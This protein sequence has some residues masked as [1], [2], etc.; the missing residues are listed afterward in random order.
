V[1][2]QT[3]KQLVSV[4][5]DTDRGEEVKYKQVDGQVL[6]SMKTREK[7][8]LLW[9]V[10]MQIKEEAN[11][12][13]V[14]VFTDQK[15][16]YFGLWGRMSRIRG[17]LRKELILMSLAILTNVSVYAQGEK[18]VLESLPNPI[19]LYCY[20][21]GASIRF[22]GQVDGVNKVLGGYI[23]SSTGN[24]SGTLTSYYVGEQPICQ[25]C[26]VADLE[27]CEPDGN[28]GLVCTRP[29][30][31][32]GDPY[33]CGSPSENVCGIRSINLSG[34]SFSSELDC[35]E[36]DPNLYCGSTMSSLFS[37]YKVS[38]PIASKQ[39][40]FIKLTSRLERTNNN[41]W[42]LTNNPSL[43]GSWKQVP[44]KSSDEIN[45]TEA[46]L[47]GI[48]LS[49]SG[50][51]YARVKNNN[52]SSCR[53][54]DPSLSFQL[55]APAPDFSLSSTQPTCNGGDNGTITI[56][57]PTGNLTGYRVTLLYNVLDNPR[58]QYTEIV[59]STS[60]PI[61]IDKAKL[62]ADNI[63]DQS[64]IVSGTWYVKVQNNDADSNKGN[65]GITKDI[66]VP[67]TPQLSPTV[68]SSTPVKCFG[69]SNGTLT[70]TINGG[71]PGFTYKFDNS[72]TATD[73]TDGT[74]RSPKFTGLSGGAHSVIVTDNNTCSSTALPFTINS[75]T[76]LLAASIQ[77]DKKIS[78]FER[79]DGELSVNTSGGQ[80]GYTY[81]WSNSTTTQSISALPAAEYTVTVTDDYGCVKTDT[82]TLTRPQKL[83]FDLSIA[84]PLSCANTADGVL[85]VT[86]V[87][88][89]QG[90]VTYSWSTDQTES[91]ISN[92]SHSVPYSVI[93]RDEKGCSATK[94]TTLTQPPAHTVSL[95]IAYP[96]EFNGSAIRCYG[97]SNG[98]ITA[99][100]RDGN[101]TIVQASR[102][103]WFKNAE[104]SS[105]EGGPTKTFIDGLGEG[106]Y[107]VKVPYNNGRCIAES[108]FIPL[109]EPDPITVEVRNENAALF[110]DQTLSCH[111]AKDAKLSATASGGTG[112]LGYSWNVPDSTKQT[113]S[114][115]GAAK[116]IVTVTDQNNCVGRDSIVVENPAKVKANILSASNYAGFGITCAG[117]TDGFI[118]AGGTG[119]TNVF[120]YSWAHN[121]A[122]ANSS[123]TNLAAGPYT[124]TVKD[125]N[126]CKADSTYQITTPK[127][128]ALSIDSL[129]NISCFN[130]N[131]GHIALLAQEGA[132]GYSFSKD[133][134]SWRAVPTFDSL[135]ANTTM[136]AYKLYVRDANHC[137]SRVT[138]AL[139]QPTQL[140]IAFQDIQPAFCT[141]SIG[142]ATAIVK[143]G[144]PNY[145]YEWKKT[146]DSVKIYSTAATL[147]KVKGGIYQVHIRDGNNCPADSIVAITSTDGAK[148]EYTSVDARCSYSADGSAQITVKGIGPF[149]VIWPTRTAVAVADTLTALNVNNLTSGTYRLSVK[150][151]ANCEAT[152]EVTI[153]AP[154]RLQL[155]E[156][157]KTI[158]TCYADC[159]GQL[160]LEAQGGVGN[161]KYDW[162]GKVNADSTQRQLCANS[163]PVLVRDGSGCELRQTI[164]LKQPDS[165]AL[166]VVYEKRATCTDGCDGALEVVGT[167]GNSGYTYQWATGETTTG[168]SN[169]CPGQYTITIGDAKGC[170]STGT[171][172]LAN[173]PPPTLNLGG[174]VT[175]CVGQTF[176]LDPGPDWTDYAWSSNVG[177]TSSAQRATLIQAG[178]YWLEAKNAL[179]CVARDTF[180]LATSRDLLRASF[181][182]PKQVY[183]G[184]TVAIIDISWPMPERIEWNLPMAMKKLRDTGDVLHGM[185]DEEG[186]Y[187]VSLTTHLGE[188]FDVIGK[189]IIVLP[190][191]EDPLGARLGFEEFV[192]KFELY[193]NPTDGTF[194]VDIELMEE[195]AITLS[196]W[197]PVVGKMVSKLSAADE[198]SY[199]P[200][201]DFSWLGPGTYVV[202]LDHAKGTKYIRFVV[203]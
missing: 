108:L 169:L 42:E 28:G 77:I 184:D 99:T 182:I 124:V 161:Y 98:K 53:A 159:N 181:L 137:R 31:Q 78:C 134:L 121:A 147:S 39:C 183:V 112:T 167:G 120:T 23:E 19:Y 2:S 114:G 115:V 128:L 170:S 46:E 85:E 48:G 140:T 96:Q 185:F 21:P 32:W 16:T 118:N 131:D 36:I 7:L 81:S 6:N 92:L 49:T 200:S 34:L 64:G 132:G 33:P 175:L 180:L 141:D 168:K 105:F 66:L 133:S 91:S 149:E 138:Q 84:Q 198:K 150:D 156:T 20:T 203:Y 158:P 94:D 89:K 24:I 197:N 126:N 25:D 148:I 130:G 171:I 129:K 136:P 189:S 186:T 178:Q 117:K 43:S 56:G 47:S 51:L 4:C 62:L 107:K 187:M 68:A 195:S 76:T 116:Y 26:I 155:A 82:E 44:N 50:L 177:F 15:T 38:A 58:E 104:V 144:V 8:S 73:P 106:Q 93:V 153:K 196:V 173:T 3:G 100:V 110:H 145:R 30:Q 55:F 95:A 119:G 41:T 5:G 164:E 14:C 22:S 166:R 97:E 192:R 191:E 174:S 37:F 162:N 65:C 75:S 74:E 190:G 146:G 151:N 176:V 35:V 101:S 139:S 103:D 199:K 123:L 122:L 29:C 45:V 9:S 71:V 12:S 67:I 1:S 83:D 172:I 11:S 179:G 57:L 165:L 163:Y 80:P 194:E 72:S 154:P 102:Y 61:T 40:G 87:V 152:L 17:S 127:A 18:W 90:T 54:S 201:F 52:C 157:S 142:K 79:N 160:T 135:L 111:N 193:P 63:T 59:S 13:P 88:N 202:R 109:R 69:E 125:Q 113:L 60:F 143:G 27:V 70:L 86:N 188:C 10:A